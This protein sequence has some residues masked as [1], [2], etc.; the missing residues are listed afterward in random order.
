[1]K[2]FFS[3]NL[4]FR[5]NLG[6]GVQPEDHAGEGQ[7]LLNQVKEGIWNAIGTKNVSV[8]GYH[9]PEKLVNAFLKQSVDGIIRGRLS[10]TKF[11]QNLRDEF[12]ID[13]FQRVALL[14]SSQGDDFFFAP[15]GIDE[16]NTKGQK[17][18]FVISANDFLGRLGI[19]PRFFIL[20]A[21]RMGDV[22]RG[23]RIS[24]S[25][26]D[27]VALVKEMENKHQDITIEHGK[28]LIENALKSGANVILAPDGVSGNLIYRT[29][30][31]LGSG[32]SHGAYYMNQELPGPVMDTSRVGPL[33]EYVGGA[34][35]ALRLIIHGKT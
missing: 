4:D 35:L 14:A 19:H 30:I 6:L 22:D 1:M 10:S 31:H 26:K 2:E 18:R 28:I 17:K 8:Q 25:I 34:I 12:A 24:R 11:L 13:E 7:P 33:E 15:V 3:R 32:R 16:C 29:L 23:E 21:G 5:V 20:S 27:A 9:S